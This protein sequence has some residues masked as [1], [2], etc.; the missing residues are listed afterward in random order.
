MQSQW[1]CFE[2]M[3]LLLLRCNIV[4]CW[5]GERLEESRKPDCRLCPCSWM[6]VDELLQACGDL[7][8]SAEGFVRSENCLLG[9]ELWN[10][11]CLLEIT[12]GIAM[13]GI[14]DRGHLTNLELF[15]RFELSD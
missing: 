2:K 12:T 1:E 11:G 13:S 9:F 3:K 7:Q 8:V 15:L 4:G 14:H 10:G 6:C 5:Y